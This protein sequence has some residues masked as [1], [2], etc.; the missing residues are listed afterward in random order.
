MKDYSDKRIVGAKL[1]G[2]NIVRDHAQCD[3]HKNTM[4]LLKKE[5]AVAQGQ[6]AAPVRLL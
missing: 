4:L 1:Y 3:Q 2:H 5:Q 6:S